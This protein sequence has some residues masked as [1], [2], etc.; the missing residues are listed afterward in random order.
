MSSLSSQLR[1]TPLLTL[2]M[3]WMHCS[4]QQRVFVNNKQWAA[5]GLSFLGRVHVAKQVLAAS[6]WYHASFQRPPEPL[7]QQLSSQLRSFLASAQQPGHS[8]DAV[9]L[10]QGNSQGSTQLPC[11]SSGQALFPGELT[12]SLP[13]AQGG[14]GLVHVPT[15]IQALQAKVVSRPLEPERLPWKVFQLYHLSQASQVR[16][17]GYGAGILFSTLGTECLQLLARQATY[18]KAFRALQPH[19]LQSVSAMLP[20]DVLNELLFFNR[21]I[22]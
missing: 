19:R 8:D 1:L 11:V 7:L 14:V 6:L 10:A 12:S 15:Q 21:R 16:T 17:L 22:P 4:T 20:H 2:N 13:S 18:V 3:L 5:R 9:A